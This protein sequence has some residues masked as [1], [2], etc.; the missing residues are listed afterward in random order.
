MF[1]ASLYVET[2]VNV[3]RGKLARIAVIGLGYVGLTS[4]VGLSSLGHSVLGID[5]NTSKVDSLKNGVVPIYEPGLSS[6]ME[7]AVE[8]GLLEFTNSFDFIDS[9]VKFAFVCVP[10]PATPQGE[11]DLS[12]V[13]SAI[14]TLT[15]RLSPGSIVVIKSTVPIGTSDSF[16]SSLETLGLE[17]AS[18]PEFLQEGSALSDFQ[19]PS[20][21]VVGALTEKVALEVMDLYSSLEAPRLLCGLSSAETIK[22]ASNSFLAVKLSFVNELAFLAMNY[23]SVQRWVLKIDH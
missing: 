18:N 19:N 1:W 9:S 16:A 4:A 21:I 2:L 8:K 14:T 22:H 5:L 20:R 3:S 6:L 10:T 7:A 15:S 12:Y 13:Q 11:A 17:I 23:P